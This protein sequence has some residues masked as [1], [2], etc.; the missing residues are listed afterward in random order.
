[1]SIINGFK[2]LTGDYSADSNNWYYRLPQSDLIVR[3]E[4]I[5]VFSKL[6]EAE[7]ERKM[8]EIQNS[9]QIGKVALI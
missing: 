6:D 8:Q 5:H 4:G 9:R 3:G 2:V 7:V 1:M